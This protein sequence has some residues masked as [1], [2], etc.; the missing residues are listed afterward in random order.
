MMLNAYTFPIPPAD[1]G[2]FDLG[3]FIALYLFALH[4]RMILLSRQ[5]G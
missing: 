1:S 3:P 5:L 2:L 4:T